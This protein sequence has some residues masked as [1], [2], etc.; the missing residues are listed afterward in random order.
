[1]S[2]LAKITGHD[3]GFP[4]VNSLE[5]SVRPDVPV[6]SI[7]PVKFPLAHQVRSHEPLARM[8][9]YSPRVNVSF[10]PCSPSDIEIGHTDDTIDSIV[11]IDTDEI[12]EYTV[13]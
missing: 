10:Q 9:F 4:F 13:Q 8:E 12:L 11:C 3:L 1:M 5:I 6:W 2:K 7:N